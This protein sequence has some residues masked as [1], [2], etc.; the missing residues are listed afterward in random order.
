M[1]TTPPSSLDEHIDEQ[2]IYV[3]ESIFEPFVQKFVDTV[4][5]RCMTLHIYDYACLTPFLHFDI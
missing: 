3:H 4:K 2:R 5:A 1:Y